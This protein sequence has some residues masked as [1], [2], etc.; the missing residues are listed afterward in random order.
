[1]MGQPPMPPPQGGVTTADTP[2]VGTDRHLKWNSENKFLELFDR[3]NVLKNYLKILTA[4]AKYF[5]DKCEEA[6]QGVGKGG[7]V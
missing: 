4:F 1:M 3:V 5:Y 2:V 6:R 7:G